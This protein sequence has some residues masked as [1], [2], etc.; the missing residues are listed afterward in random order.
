MFHLFLSKENI[1][2]KNFFDENLRRE[3]TI[4]I[5]A[6]L[7]KVRLKGMKNSNTKAHYVTYGKLHQLKRHCDLF[8]AI[9]VLNTISGNNVDIKGIISNYECSSL[10]RSLFDAG[11]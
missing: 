8:R 11:G 6:P 1:S 3:S 4:N 5:W 10:A 2:T 7:K 9:A